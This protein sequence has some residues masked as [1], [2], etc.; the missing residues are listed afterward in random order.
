MGLDFKRVVFVKSS[1]AVLCFFAMF[2]VFFVHQ[3]TLGVEQEKVIELYFFFIFEY[4]ICTY[5]FQYVC[6]N[7]S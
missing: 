5:T 3:R 6:L 4:V 1:V 2:L 7:Q